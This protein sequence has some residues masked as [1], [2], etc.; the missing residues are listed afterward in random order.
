MKA[1]RLFTIAALSACLAYVPQA[2][3]RRINLKT[4]AGSKQLGG[5]ITFDIDSVTTQVGDK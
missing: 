5:S 3:A 2:D 1:G 4:Q